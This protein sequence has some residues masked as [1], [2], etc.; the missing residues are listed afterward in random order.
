MRFAAVYGAQVAQKREAGEVIVGC[1][2]VEEARYLSDWFEHFQLFR[3]NARL[4]CVP[5]SAPRQKHGPY[6]KDS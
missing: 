2:D 5:I 3:S 1:V 4:V 6:T